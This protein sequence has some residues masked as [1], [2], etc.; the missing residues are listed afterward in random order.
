[1]ITHIDVSLVLRRSVCDLYSNLVTRPTGAAVRMGIEQQIADRM[2][3]SL[4]IIDFT[5]VSLLDFS[6]A[7]EVVAKLVLKYCAADAATEAYFLFRGISESHVDAIESVLERHRIAIVV[8][9]ADG[10]ATMLGP[11]TEAERVAWETVC[12][13]RRLTPDDVMALRESGRDDVVGVLDQLHARRLLMRF[14]DEYVSLEELS[15]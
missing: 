2:E 15:S 1:M 12:T 6:C 3:R 9:D 7:D 5:N 13:R 8:Q 4:T 11:T 10:H 14:E